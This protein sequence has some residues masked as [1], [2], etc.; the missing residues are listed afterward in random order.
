MYRLTTDEL[1][2]TGE[3]PHFLTV[4]VEPD[5]SGYDA[6][7]PY[8]DADEW[9]VTVHYSAALP[10]ES[11]TEITRIDTTHGRPHFDRLFEADRPKTWLPPDFT[12]RDAETLLASRWRT[13]AE[14]HRRN[15]DS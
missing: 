13:Y 1:G 9:C 4:A 3:Q 12:L 8:R 7:D 2:V 6:F 11:D 10:H 5:P 15:H 14:K